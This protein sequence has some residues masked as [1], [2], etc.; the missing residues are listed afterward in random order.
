MRRKPAAK[1]RADEQK[2]HKRPASRASEH[3]ITKPNDSRTKVNGAVVQRRFAF[4]PGEICP[5]CARPFWPGARS[6]ET[7]IV[8]EQKSAEVVVAD[9]EAGGGSRIHEA[10]ESL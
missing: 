9:V 5:A 1:L 3:T 7:A 4:L 8:T 2:S 6:S 10:P